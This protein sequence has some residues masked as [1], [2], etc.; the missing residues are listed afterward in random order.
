MAE[1]SFKMQVIES[2]KPSRFVLDDIEEEK[3]SFQ[4][5]LEF[6]KK[7]LI[8]ISTEALAE[9]QQKGFDR[10]PVVVV[11]NSFNKPIENVHPLGKIEFVAR[12]DLS[13]I[14][15]FIYDAINIRSP[16]VTGTYLKYNIV[17]MNGRVIA[18]SRQELQAFFENYQPRP[19][20]K[21]RFINATPYAR[22]LERYSK[23]AG[24]SGS[25][26]KWRKS[27]DKKGRSGEMRKYKVKDTVKEAMHVLAENGAYFLS[28]RAALNKYRRNAFIKY[29]S[30]P[31]QYLG[32][33]N[34]V[35]IGPK[36]KA[37]RRTFKKTNTP[38]LY[39]TILVYV[40]ETG[41]KGIVQWVLVQSG[42]Q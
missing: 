39:P 34:L 29:E 18:L 19:G 17:A 33:E 31:G 37:L 4:D 32:I 28:A 9:E 22:K 24:K 1:F 25:G 35:I 5:L 15:L 27:T 6:T 16:K 14:A 36:G 3:I 11:D 26:I 2:G 41:I 23:Y 12:Q 30:L 38:Y 8:K 13:E 40:H 10:N 42:Q 7:S 21:L 20:D